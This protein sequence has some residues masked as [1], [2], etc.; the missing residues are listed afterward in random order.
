MSNTL[1]YGDNLFLLSQ[2]IDEAMV[3]LVYEGPPLNADPARR[4]ERG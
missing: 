3:G 4:K 2:H 1:F